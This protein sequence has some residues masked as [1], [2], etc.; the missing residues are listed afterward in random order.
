M[1]VAAVISLL[2]LAGTPHPALAAPKTRAAAAAFRHGVHA[3]KTKDYEEAVRALAR[4]YALEADVE[5]LFAWAQAER[6]LDQCEAALELYAKLLASKLPEEN[7]AV[8]RDKQAE[9]TQIL[10]GKAP[11]PEPPAPVK[12]VPVHVDAPPPPETPPGPPSVLP[13]PAPHHWYRDPVGMTLLVGGTGAALV[14]GV[15]LASA[16]SL[17][18]EKSSAPTYQ[19]FTHD[20][21]RAHTRGEIGWVVGGLGVVAAIGGVVYLAA[22]SDD[23]PPPKTGVTWIAPSGTGIALGGAF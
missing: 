8:V 19:Q 1:R 7:K 11:P 3:Y 14:G 16:A 15:F 6:Q 12:P 17:D 20:A 5:T 22:R 13:P 4:S 23:A 2:A 18:S 10:A 21:D 9:C